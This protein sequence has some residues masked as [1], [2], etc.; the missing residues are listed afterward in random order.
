M[1]GPETVEVRAVDSDGLVSPWATFT[2]NCTAGQ[3]GN[4]C[5]AGNICQ[6]TKLCYEDASCNID[7]N[8]CQ[9]CA[10]GCGSGAC[11]PPPSPTISIKA[12]PSLVQQ[13]STTQVTW[14][15][16]NVTSCNIS[17]NNGDGTGSNAT[18]LWGC[19]GAACENAITQTSS[20]LQDQTI[21]TLMC[22]EFDNSTTSKQAIVNVVPVFQEK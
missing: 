10:Y 21:Y 9:T 18:G 13:A 8:S 7:P 1:A 16:T 5:T 3:T 4:Q 14:S 20:P 6:G 15:A 17:G 22:T 12:V 11:L 2:F 19:N